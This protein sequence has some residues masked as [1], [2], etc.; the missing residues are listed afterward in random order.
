MQKFIS[1]A[2][3]LVLTATAIPLFGGDDLFDDLFDELTPVST[4]FNNNTVQSNCS[5][6]CCDTNCCANNRAG[7]YASV[8]WVHMWRERTGS[9]TVL[10]LDPNDPLFSAS[11]LNIND[12]AGIDTRI[13]YLN[14][15]GQGVEFRYFWLDKLDG[16]SNFTSASGLFGPATIDNEFISLNRG[17]GTA[18]YSTEF[19]SVELLGREPVSDYHISYGFRYAE[20]DELFNPVASAGG[21]YEFETENRLYG[22]QIGLD[23]TLWGNG[24]NFRVDGDLKTGIYYNDA[25]AVSQVDITGINRLGSSSADR[26]AFLSELGLTA[27][28][29]ISCCFSL[30][31]GYRFMYLDG[32]A[33][34]ADHV[35]NTT[36]FA[37]IDP[38]SVNVDRSSLFL[39]GLHVGAVLQF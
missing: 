20:L 15:C 24:N 32:V 1:T 7:W 5:D 3:V 13:G 6:S 9:N 10:L 39:H 30:R 31:A 34:A 26:T 12:S 21:S 33:L 17:I 19:Q 18:Y 38:A 8:D 16:N 25:S 14:S 36:G 11:D 35:P 23:R 2:V 22:L 27:V 4:V 28:Y 29:D 37:L